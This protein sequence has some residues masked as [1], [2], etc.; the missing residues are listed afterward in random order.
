MDDDRSR[1]VRESDKTVDTDVHTF[2]GPE[3]EAVRELLGARQTTLRSGLGCDGHYAD[4]SEPLRLH[5][6]SSQPTS[7]KE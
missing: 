4:R 3:A 2:F 5:H 1:V 7:S 6:R